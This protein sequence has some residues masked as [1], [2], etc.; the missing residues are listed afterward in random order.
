[1]KLDFP[2]LTWFHGKLL[3]WAGLEEQ[4]IIEKS[5]ALPSEGLS[6]ILLV[7]FP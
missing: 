5:Q 2:R 1:M 6:L 3:V 7:E 4:V